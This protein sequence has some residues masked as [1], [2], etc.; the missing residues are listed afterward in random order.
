MFLQALIFILLFYYL[1]F[2]LKYSQF[3]M[4]YQF[5]LYGKVMQPYIYIHS[6]SYVIFHHGLSKEIGYSSVCQRIGPHCLSILIIIVCIYQPQ[7]FFIF[8]YFRYNSTHFQRHLSL[9]FFPQPL[10]R[11]N[12]QIFYS[13]IFGYVYGNRPGGCVSSWLDVGAHNILKLRSQVT[14]LQPIIPGTCHSSQY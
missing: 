12:F 7:T 6:L 13:S 5:L 2:L 4:L 11:N 3:T 1:I 14:L 8:Y 10:Y 9:F